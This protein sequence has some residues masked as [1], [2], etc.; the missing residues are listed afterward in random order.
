MPIWNSQMSNYCV[1]F[2]AFV[3]TQ[4]WIKRSALPLSTTS[5]SDS[6]EDGA[7]DNFTEILECHWAIL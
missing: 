4:S 5:L 1:F 7:L 2:L 6:D 3:E